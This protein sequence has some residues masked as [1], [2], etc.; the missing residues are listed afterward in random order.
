[1]TETLERLILLHMKND[2][3]KLTSQFCFS[4]AESKDYYL[5]I[6]LSVLFRDFVVFQ[7]YRPNNSLNAYVASL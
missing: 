5:S 4:K 6:D 2:F 3:F 7:I 1:M